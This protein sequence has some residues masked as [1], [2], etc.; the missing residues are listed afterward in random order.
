MI[1]LADYGNLC[2]YFPGTDLIYDRLTIEIWTVA[3]QDSTKNEH[4]ALI[5]AKNALHKI[6]T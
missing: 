5:R 3:P 4:L 1:L 6:A 2:G